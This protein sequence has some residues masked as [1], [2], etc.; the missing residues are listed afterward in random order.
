MNKKIEY[1]DVEKIEILRRLIELRKAGKLNGIWCDELHYL[2]IRYFG[3]GDP[4][5]LE[6]SV[7]AEMTG[8]VHDPASRGPFVQRKP[9]EFCK[10]LVPLIANRQKRA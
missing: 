7:A 10:S 5:V 8:F 2:K 3:I 4:D 9:A 1:T 6:W